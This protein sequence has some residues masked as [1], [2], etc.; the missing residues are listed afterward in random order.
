MTDEEKQ[1][2]IRYLTAKAL[3]SISL[4][5]IDQ[6]LIDSDV[7][8]GLDDAAYILGG[9]QTWARHLMAELDTTETD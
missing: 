2:V 4:A 3:L 6:A 8:A 5:D 1:M 7:R 9:C